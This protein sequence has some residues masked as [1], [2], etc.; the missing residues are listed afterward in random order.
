MEE[1]A[2]EFYHAKTCHALKWVHTM[3]KARTQGEVWRREFLE[4]LTLA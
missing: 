1:Y 4:N 2:T 3:L